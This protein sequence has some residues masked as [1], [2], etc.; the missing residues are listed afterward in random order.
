MAAVTSQV[1]HTMRLASLR[2]HGVRCVCPSPFGSPSVSHIRAMRQVLHANR[3]V[4]L[5]AL[6]KPK[7]AQ[8]AFEVLNSCHTH[9]GCLPEIITVWWSNP[10]ISERA[11]E[12]G[13]GWHR[14]VGVGTDRPCCLVCSGA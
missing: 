13:T 10:I 11:R 12:G 2:V 4:A 1:P 7:A 14:R 6:K 3:G 8:K 5:R 9:T